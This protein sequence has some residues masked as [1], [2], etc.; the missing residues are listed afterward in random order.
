MITTTLY[1]A[2][3]SNSTSEIPALMDVIIPTTI[4]NAADELTS[5]HRVHAA[6]AGTHGL[7]VHDPYNARSLPEP[8]FSRSSVRP[9][10]PNSIPLT[11]QWRR[12]R[13]SSQG[14]TCPPPSFQRGCCLCW[15]PL[16]WL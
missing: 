16:C 8:R 4:K 5:L 6:V 1:M 14:S 13:C 2:G 15:R 11:G 12:A 9:M 10:A 3:T 7:H